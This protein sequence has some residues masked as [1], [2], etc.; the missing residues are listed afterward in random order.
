[1]AAIV[2]GRRDLAPGYTDSLHASCV[3]CHNDKAESAGKPNLGR[4]DTCH[5]FTPGLDEV[6]GGPA[7][8]KPPAGI[9][10]ARAMLKID[11]DRDGMSV[12]FPHREHQGFLGD[13]ASCD[14]CHHLDRP[15][16]RFTACHLCHMHMEESRS[17]FT[18]ALH[19][20]KVGEELGPNVLSTDA[21]VCAACHEGGRVRSGQDAR[22][23]VSCH[24]GDMRMS[25]EHTAT[26]RDLAPGYIKS[27]HGSCMGCHEK[28]GERLKRPELSAC[29]TC[30][31]E[32]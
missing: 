30:H 23:C 12:R 31:N 32:E 4:C 24:E 7:F 15:N 2:N 13:E 11:G 28:L 17:I 6:A 14:K 8:V 5:E 1:M 25:S 26:S 27:L 9:D 16:D 10:H 22:A 18:H 21:E 19:I 29:D 20:R 3:G